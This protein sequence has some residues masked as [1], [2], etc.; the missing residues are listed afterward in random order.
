M[1]F[2]KIGDKVIYPN[3]GLGIIE[4]IQEEDYDG[5][6]FEIYYLRIISNNTLILIPFSNAEEIGVRKLISSKSIGEIFKFMKNGSVNVTMNW[7][8]RHKE[9]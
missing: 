6:R 5:E 7:K 9:K 4:D 3:Q 1:K 8:G 2:F